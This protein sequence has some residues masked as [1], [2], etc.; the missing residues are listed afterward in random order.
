M[1]TVL[2]KKKILMP[3][4]LLAAAWMPAQEIAAQK[5]VMCLKTNT[6]KYIE[7]CRVSMIVVVDGGS[8]FDILTKD[9]DGAQGVSSIS[10]EKHSSNIDLSGYQ[11][12]SAD[13]SVYI[14]VSLP[15]WLQTDKGDNM[16]VNNVSMLANVDG[17][18]FEVLAKSGT[19]LTDV[20]YVTFYRSKTAW[21]A[22]TNGGATAIDPVKQGD[23]EQLQLL[24]PVYTQLSLSGC[25]DA[26]TAVVYSLN[27]TQVGG[28]K[29]EGGCT[30]VNVADLPAGIYVV[31]VGKKALKFTKK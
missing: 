6:N 27:G 31:K 16:K 8:T 1:K 11:G 5:N 24:T 25:G 26:K 28:A 14:D 21:N 15:V 30:N 9:G 4:L 7:C 29:V 20:R 13:G 17:S 23:I 19:N 3:L 2:Q 22:Q 18:R 12:N 10:F